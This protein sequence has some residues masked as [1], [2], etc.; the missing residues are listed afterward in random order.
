MGSLP[1]SSTAS[2]KIDCIAK[3]SIPSARLVW[4]PHTQTR[5]YT[6]HSRK[7]G[8]GGQ[9]TTAPLAAVSWRQP[10][11]LA[12]LEADQV[13]AVTTQVS[14]S[15]HP[16]QM[17][18]VVRFR[19]IAGPHPTTIPSRPRRCGNTPQ[20]FPACTAHRHR[21][22]HQGDCLHATQRWSGLVYSVH[23]LFGGECETGDRG[24]G[25][26]DTARKHVLHS[27]VHPP[28]PC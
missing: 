15:H 28:T 1:G 10:L 24:R 11:W 20:A 26:G 17:G 19:L 12:A 21:R 23:T 18:P 16:N 8:I 27:C 7:R 14:P 5:Q 13:Q 4:V 2:S 6:V 22:R 3:L 9:V 25:D